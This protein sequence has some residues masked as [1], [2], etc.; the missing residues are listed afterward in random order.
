MILE[1]K[2]KLAIRDVPN[3]PKE[4]IIFKDI[5]PIMLDAKLSSEVLDYLVDF[6][7]RFN[8]H[9]SGEKYDED[10]IPHIKMIRSAKKNVY[11]FIKEN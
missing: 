1:E 2:L 5:S 7:K 11:S 9:T 6:Y 4:G 10:G 8:L 3:F